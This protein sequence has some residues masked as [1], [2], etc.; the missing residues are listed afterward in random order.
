MYRRILRLHAWRIPGRPPRVAA[1]A[2]WAPLRWEGESRSALPTPGGSRTPASIGQI[3]GGGAK[4]DGGRRLGG[5]IARPLPRSVSG[6]SELHV[7]LADDLEVVRPGT[8]D[9][10]GHAD[11]QVRRLEELDVQTARQHD[12]V[13]RKD[14]VGRV[15]V[16]VIQW[17][18]AVDLDGGDNGA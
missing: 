13:H 7:E 14:L 15:D 18:Y 1:L 16:A 9:R 4:K 3:C 5:D 11:H 10:G 8:R 17:R 12:A 2:P 6:G